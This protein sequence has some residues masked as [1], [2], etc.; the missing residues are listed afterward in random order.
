MRAPPRPLP[1]IAL[2]LTVTPAVVEHPRDII[3]IAALLRGT[4]SAAQAVSYGINSTSLVMSAASAINFGLWGLALVP[5]WLVVREIS[6]EQ[7]SL[8][9]LRAPE[10]SAGR[11]AKDA[12]ELEKE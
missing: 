7:P 6:D 10:E 12:S 5:G 8:D 1:L 4:E 2:T 3:R 11:D 9:N